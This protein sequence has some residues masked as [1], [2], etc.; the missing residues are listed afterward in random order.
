MSHSHDTSA[1]ALE[2][3][4][5]EE[6][7]ATHAHNYARDPIGSRDCSLQWDAWKAALA[8]EK[9][10]AREGVTEEMVELAC[11]KYYN[12]GHKVYPPV[13]EAMRAALEAVAQSLPDAMAEALRQLEYDTN[14]AALTL[15]QEG[16]RAMCIE[17]SKRLRSIR[18]AM[19]DSDHE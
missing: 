4:R 11:R 19:K 10:R 7:Y 13:F 1:E 16:L 6:W 18:K 2:R 12:S 14:Q 5:F 15:G 8:A 17:A 3:K 9:R